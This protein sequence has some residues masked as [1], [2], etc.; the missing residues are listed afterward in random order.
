MTNTASARLTRCVNCD[1]EVR[2]GVTDL[3]FDYGDFRITVEGVPAELCNACDEQYIDG[4]L[5]LALSEIVSEIAEEYATLVKR[6]TELRGTEVRKPYG[7]TRLP[8]ASQG[9]LVYA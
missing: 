6:M 5:G 8:G 4:P 2:D 7:N 1:T 3:T 9:Q